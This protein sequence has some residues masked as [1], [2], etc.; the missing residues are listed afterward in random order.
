MYID[1]RIRKLYIIFVQII[2]G[3][4]NGGS[5]NRGSTVS[6]QTHFQMMLYL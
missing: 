3:S 2:E 6:D 5:D 4:C 1:V